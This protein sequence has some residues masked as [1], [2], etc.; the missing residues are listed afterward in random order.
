MRLLVSIVLLMTAAIGCT[1]Q[2]VSS[3]QKDKV[4]PF[5][6]EGNGDSYAGKLYDHIIPELCADGTHVDSTIAVANDGS[7]SLLKEDCAALTTPVALADS[8][9]TFIDNGQS[10]IYRNQTYT[11]VPAQPPARNKVTCTGGADL[12]ATYKGRGF[13]RLEFDTEIFF[14]PNN[15][16]MFTNL[17]VRFYRS[18]ILLDSLLLSNRTLT[19]PNMK[20]LNQYSS[21]DPPSYDGYKTVIDLYADSSMAQFGLV[22]A[23]V[24]GTIPQINAP[25]KQP[26]N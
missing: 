17:T 21:N 20:G 16:V 5:R 6:A 10:L 23:D 2:N 22:L 8:D 24:E 9:V 19:G 13:D 18:G 15:P 3:T 12:S 1:N 26:R 11:E 4:L 14:E 25:C 7:K